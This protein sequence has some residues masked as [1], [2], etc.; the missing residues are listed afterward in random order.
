MKLSVPKLALV[1]LLMFAGLVVASPAQAG[2]LGYPTTDHASF[3]VDIP[4]GWEVTPGDD[5]GDF[6][7]VNSDSGVY[8]AFRTIAGSDSAMQEAIEDSVGYLK[9][10]YK[11]VDVG[12]PVD[13]KQAGLT[14]STWTAPARTKTARR[15]LP[16]GLAGAEGRP[17]RRDL[18]RGAGGRQGRYRRGSKALNSFRAP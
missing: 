3:L 17:H 9:E 8:L 7:D 5:E 1:P 12:E 6:V 15:R 18:V 10:N 16:H 13:T 2:V 4:D 11:N 14:A